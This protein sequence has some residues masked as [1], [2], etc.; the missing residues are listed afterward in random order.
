M[1]VLANIINGG[2]HV[3]ANATIIK[4]T[5]FTSKR[6]RLWYS[7]V[8]ITWIT[9]IAAKLRMGGRVSCTDAVINSV[10]D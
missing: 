10:N 4:P 1:Y 9:V 3:M 6:E 2:R 7:S 5:A 8:M